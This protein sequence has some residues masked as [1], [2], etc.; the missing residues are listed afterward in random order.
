[1]VGRTPAAAKQLAS[2]VRR[3]VRD[4]GVPDPDPDPARQHEVV[5]AFFAA[6]RRGDFGAL[7]A[8][9]HPGVVARADFG[10]RRPMVLIRGAEA[11]ARQ[12]LLG[13]ALPAAHLH[14]ALVNGALGAVITVH[15]RPF[16]VMSFTVAD[17]KITEIDTIAD[18][19]RVAKIAAPV[20]TR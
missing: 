2:R 15:G 4:A 8:L 3:R 5:D 10:A 14:P 19:E 17:G 11:V 20:L 6:A 18:P 1:V 16:T 7:V 12:S 13:A 9:L